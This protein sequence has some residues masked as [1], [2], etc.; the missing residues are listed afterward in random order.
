MT[1]H[2]AEALV[3]R[4]MQ[5]KEKKNS[6]PNFSTRIAGRPGSIQ[7]RQDCMGTRMGMGMEFHFDRPT[8]RPIV[9]D[10]GPYS[11]ARMW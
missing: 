9:V 1:L 7:D 10:P 4:K 11:V 3:K 2:K 6:C 8:T 5:Q